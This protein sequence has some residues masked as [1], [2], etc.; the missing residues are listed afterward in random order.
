MSPAFEPGFFVWRRLG[1]EA[2]QAT[3]KIKSGH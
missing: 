2:K 1:T 3:T